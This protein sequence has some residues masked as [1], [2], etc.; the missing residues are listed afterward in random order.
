MPGMTDIRVDLVADLLEEP[1]DDW[2]RR[3]HRMMVLASV[4][5]PNLTRSWVRRQPNSA[6]ALLFRAWADL[7]QGRRDGGL[8]DP[9]ETVDACYSAAELRPE[10]P[11]PWL[12]L[13]R[14]LRL[15]G[16]PTQ[17]VFPVWREVT[18]RDAW[19]R[20]A[21]LQM[22][23]YLSP[24]EC[25]SH[26]QVLDFLDATRAG[27]PSNAPAVGVELVAMV[28]RYWRAVS[29]GGV[30]ALMAARLWTQP[31]AA[32]ALDRAATDWPRPG[33]LR[34]A[35]ALADLNTLAYGLV[36]AKRV[37]EAGPAFQLI[38]GTVTAFPWKL[39]GDPIKQFGHWQAQAQAQA[40][41]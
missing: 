3:T 9:Q 22:L 40:R 6:D 8:A 25:G 27:M 14:A 36:H 1:G 11:G 10:D 12:A 29:A 18:V 5:P 7:V 13:L 30:D 26:T 34:H 2:D 24:E 32:A 17:E 41:R 19:H 37:P 16:R 21:Y 23:G 33:F 4:A 31:P 20:E 28:D 15:L 39:D 38:G 35:A